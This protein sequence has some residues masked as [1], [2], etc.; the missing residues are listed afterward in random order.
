MIENKTRLGHYVIEVRQCTDV[1]TISTR[2]RRHR[3]VDDVND[4]NEV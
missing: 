1:D 3:D 2:Y 4:V